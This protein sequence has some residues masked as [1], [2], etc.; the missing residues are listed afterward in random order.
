MGHDKRILRFVGRTNRRMEMD[1]MTNLLN[2]DN[3]IMIPTM[4]H[5]HPNPKIQRER[6]RKGCTESG[7]ELQPNFLC[8]YL[9]TNYIHTVS[10]SLQGKYT[11]P[12][13]QD[14]H[15]QYTERG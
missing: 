8:M 3:I 4:R 12:T 13:G 10:E 6:K 11:V 9:T 1:W 15:T 2:T 7:S 14:T 5:G